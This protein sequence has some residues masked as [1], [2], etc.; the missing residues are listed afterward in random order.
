MTLIEDDRRGE[1]DR[2]WAQVMK[3]SQ[4]LWVA[5]YEPMTALQSWG[6]DY[7]AP[8]PRRL[9][10]HKNYRANALALML[11]ACPAEMVADIN[12]G[13]AHSLGEV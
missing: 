11:I 7:L 8:N 4:S 3:H 13:I 9:K 10:T 6:V 5:G 2:V 1:H 12:L